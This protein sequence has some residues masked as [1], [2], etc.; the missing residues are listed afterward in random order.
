MTVKIVSNNDGSSGSRW[1]GF[2]SYAP[3]TYSVLVDEEKVAEIY[4]GSFYSEKFNSIY[5]GWVCS[6]TGLGDQYLSALKKKVLKH[7][8]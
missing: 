4:Q 7:F 3:N 1:T 5:E 2:S 6:G 8:S